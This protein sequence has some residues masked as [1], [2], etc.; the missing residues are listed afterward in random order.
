M[1]EAEKQQSKFTALLQ[2]RRSEQASKAL[3]T[4][5]PS[6]PL[7]STFGRSD[8]QLPRSGKVLEGQAGVAGRARS[9]KTPNR[10]RRSDPNFTQVTAY[11]PLELHT[12]IKMD[13]LKHNR[14][15]PEDP[16]DFSALVS[17][18]LDSW[19]QQQKRGAP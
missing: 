14:G 16:L 10:G 4:P 7:E 8:T 17:R 15:N 9:G 6:T 3:E 18:L 13:L 19:H 2:A 1:K 11:I 12:D 5:Q